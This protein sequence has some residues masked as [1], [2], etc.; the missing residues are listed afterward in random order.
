MTFF[1]MKKIHQYKLLAGICVMS[2]FASCNFEEI[3]TNPF[4]MSE[5][6]GA[7]DGFEVGGLVTAMQRTVI[8]VGTQADD[9]DV[10]NAYQIA[11]HLSGDCWSGFFGENNSSGWNSGN[12]NTTYFLIDDWV[13]ETY[14]QSYTNAL[15]PWK[16]LKMAA[17]KNNTPE[18]F[19]LAQILKISAWHKALESFGPMP[20]SHAADA[21]MNIPFDAEK[22]I[23]EAMF[24]DLT[25]A[26]A[27][28]TEKSEN[29]VNVMGTYDAVYAGNATKWVK[30]ANSLMFR[31][32]M[33]VRFADEQL[34]KKY[35]TQA[36]KH[37]VG[38]M[39]A[40]D[41][42]AQM[43]QG[44]GMTFRNN[45]EWLAGNYNEARMGSSM[46]SYLMGYKDPRLSAYFLPVSDKC[47][48]GVEAYDGNKY[49]AV[50]PG[51]THGQNSDYESFSKPNIQSGTPTYWLRASEVY[52]LRAE[53]ALVWG[54]EFGSADALYKQ[55]IEMSFQENGVSASADDYM[56]TGLIPTAH[57]VGG[58]NYNYSAAAPCNTTVKFEGSNEEKLE[59]IMIQKWIA[60]FPNG[61]E[62]WTEW[63]RTGYPKLNPIKTLRGQS[64]GATIEG[65]VRRMIYP[66]S[67][68]QTKEGEDIY[69]AALG[70]LKDR[71]GNPENI[72]MSSTRLWWDCK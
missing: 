31:L 65:G 42:A 62:A 24:N 11:Y 60:L 40:K 18:V 38:V 23:Y 12:N 13:K 33:R 44:A 37:S 20:Y 58:W 32:A 19:A 15:D 61:Q 35:A 29:G 67:F 39:T 6:E 36:V 64:Q 63:R 25:E 2:L 54:G 68:Y 70:L 57:Q 5:G 66:T 43:S 8:P 55:G 46:F 30:Y 9:T 27:I 14:T 7:M 3:N 51:H 69:R 71:A 28:M 34:A 48:Y 41:D 72:D 4:E 21:S 52:F 10:I 45:I 56:N 50:P 59:K 22:D 47:N 49:Q 17:E 16:K 26:I 1:I 53:A